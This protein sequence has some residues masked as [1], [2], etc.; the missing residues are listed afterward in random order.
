MYQVVVIDHS[1][2]V[3]DRP[4]SLPLKFQDALDLAILLNADSFLDG[5]CL[6]E[7][8]YVVSIAGATHGVV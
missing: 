4:V 8:S 1:G 2:V 3:P 6:K 7:E 5:Y